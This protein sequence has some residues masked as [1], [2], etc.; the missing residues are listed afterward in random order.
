MADSANSSGEDRQRIEQ[1]FLE[2]MQQE[3]LRLSVQDHLSGVLR[4]L[5]SIAFQRMGLS[6]TTRADR[7]LEQTRIAIDA[8]RALVDVLAGSLPRDEVAMYRSTLAQ[9]QMAFV[10]AI[11][12]QK[13]EAAGEQAVPEAAY[14]PQP[15]GEAPGAVSSD[16]T[17]TET[18][19]E[20]E[21]E[22][23]TGSEPEP[24]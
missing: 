22:A 8:F 20:A 21:T 11:D 14:E 19:T 13:E 5:P 24:E 17:E 9:M 7:D 1:E 23:E 18:E 10:G 3:L 2:R 16:E 12:Q 4:S 6:E 15:S